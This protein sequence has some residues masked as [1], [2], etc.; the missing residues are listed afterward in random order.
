[1]LNHHVLLYWRVKKSQMLVLVN[2]QEEAKEAEWWPDTC[3]SEVG[4]QS[5]EDQDAP[6]T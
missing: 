6:S 4:V 2:H 1:M 5:L 3:L